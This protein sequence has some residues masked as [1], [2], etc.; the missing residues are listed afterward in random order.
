MEEEK[1]LIDEWIDFK[2]ILLDFGIRGN[3]ETVSM[4]LEKGR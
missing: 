1:S 2:W 3:E 4:E